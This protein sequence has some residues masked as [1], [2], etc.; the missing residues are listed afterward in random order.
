MS[1]TAE[2]AMD[3]DGRFLGAAVDLIANIGAY[4]SQYGAVHPLY[5]RHHVDRRLRHPGARRRRSPA[6]T[7]TPARSTPI[8]ARGG[9]KRPSCSRSWS[10]PARATSASARD[11]IRRRNFIRPEQFPYRTADRPALRRRRVRR[12]HDAGHGARRLEGL[13]RAAG[14]SRRRPARS[15][16]SAWRPI[17][18]PAPFAGS[19]P[20]HVE[21]NGDGT[22]TLL[23]GTQTNGQGHA[24]AYAQFV[25]EKLDID[26]RRRSSCTRA[27]PT[28]STDGGGT[29]GSRSIPLGGVS[30]SRAGEDLAEKIRQHR[31]RRAGGLGRR[32]RAGR[33]HGAH[34][35]H[36]PLDRLCGAS[37]RRPRSRTTSRASAS[38]CRTSAPIRT[39]RISAR[40]RSIRRPA[41]PRSSATRSSTISASR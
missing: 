34:R 20:A 18:R 39:A 19:E 36:R 2:M 40:S 4:I 11:E 38:S 32:H 16:A 7:P 14:G 21:L 5:R 26:D 28:S 29:G 3:E 35:R 27:T 12:P 13:R 24:T 1:S 17:S 8:A 15:A 9:R 23:I 6:S 22:V 25:A 37:P 10:T 30:A 33:R 31:R 41:R